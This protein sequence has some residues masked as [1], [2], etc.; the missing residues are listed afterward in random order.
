M[1]GNA[2][3]TPPQ[4]QLAFKIQVPGEVDFPGI[5]DEPLQIVVEALRSGSTWDEMLHHLP[6]IS[7]ESARHCGLLG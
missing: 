1:I 2:Q 7:R 4:E 6:D 3:F 5:V